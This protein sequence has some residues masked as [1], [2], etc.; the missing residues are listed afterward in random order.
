MDALGHINNIY[1]FEYF[2][3]VR[4][5]YM[6]K[7]SPTWDWNKHMFVIAHI[8]CDYYKEIK[9]T[10]PNVRIK[11]RTSTLSNKSFEMEYLIVSEGADGKETIHARG[12]SAQV[13]IDMQKKK[14]I[15][16][17][18]WLRNDMIAYEPSLG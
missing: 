15:A 13:M 16:I 10:T 14:S 1:Y 5:H 17:P 11:V 8:E 18:A 2:Q 4:G 7:M 12:K 3:I 6:M 9:L